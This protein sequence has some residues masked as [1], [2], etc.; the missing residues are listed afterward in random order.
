M[1]IG[2]EI[3]T[4]TILGVPY[5]NHS[6]MGPQNSLSLLRPLY[7]TQAAC[8]AHRRFQVQEFSEFFLEVESFGSKAPSPKTLKE[9]VPVKAASALY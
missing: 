1:T 4:C 5:Y 9:A 3:I 8:R 2:A 7:Y 6:I